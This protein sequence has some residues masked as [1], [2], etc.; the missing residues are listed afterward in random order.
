LFEGMGS[1]EFDRTAEQGWDNTNDKGDKVGDVIAK[2]KLVVKT[3][4]EV[5]AAD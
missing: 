1:L 2:L 5:L 3:A 4:E